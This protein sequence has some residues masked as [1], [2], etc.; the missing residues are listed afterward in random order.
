MIVFVWAQAENGVIGK[1]GVMPWHLPNDLKHFKEVTLNN[2][3]VM[4]RKTYQ[5]LPVKP[6]PQRENIIMTRQED[7][8]LDEDVLIMHSKEEILNY[9][10]EENK[11]L[12]ITGGGQIY[13]LFKDEVDILYQTIIHENFEGDTTFPEMDWDQFEEVASEYVDESEGHEYSHT[14]KKFK[15]I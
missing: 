13:E 6:F 15:R 9:G 3:V 1:D 14:F 2:T 10:K 4:G 11:D 8:S 7:F 5:D 12:Y